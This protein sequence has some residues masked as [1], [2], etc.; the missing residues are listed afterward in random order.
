MEQTFLIPEALSDTIGRG[1]NFISFYGDSLATAVTNIGSSDRT[2]IVNKEIDCDT[3]TTIPA[4]ISLIVLKEGLITIASG[5][6]LTINGDFAAGLYQIFDGDGA[7]AGLTKSYPEWWGL[8]T[9]PGTT[10]MTAEIQAAIDA[11]KGQHGIVHFQPEAYLATDVVD[12]ENIIGFSLSG[13]MGQLGTSGTRII[14]AHTGKAIVSLVGSMLVKWKD[15]EL[16][17]DTTTTPKIGLL[18]GRSSAASAGLHD[19]Q[20]LKI[21]G[22]FTIAGYYNVASEGNIHYGSFIYVSSPIC[23][24]HFAQDDWDSIGGLTGSSMEDET[25]IGGTIANYNTTATSTALR[26]YIGSATGHFRMDNTMIGKIGGDSFILIYSGT[27]TGNTT[28]PIVLNVFGESDGVTNPDCGI[29]FTTY[30]DG[31]YYISGLTINARFQ[32]VDNYILFDNNGTA[33]VPTTGYTQLIG[34]KIN[35]PY[36]TTGAKPIA[37]NRVD[38]SDLHFEGANT[39]AITITTAYE[40]RI[41]SYSIPTITYS[42]N[43][44]ISGAGHVTTMT[45][46]FSLPLV[47]VTNVSFAADGATE[48]FEVPFGRRFVPI[49]VVI[50]AGA[51]AGATTTIAFSGPDVANDWLSAQTLSNLDAQYDAVIIQPVPNATPVQIKSYAAGKKFYATVANHSGGATNTVYLYGLIY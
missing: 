34:A 11:V 1:V 42:Y 22:S 43:N 25:W 10:D 40:S 39:E 8:N 35:I 33:S 21:Y 29:H 19:F 46:G 20:G 6:T 17:G 9:T 7:T 4:N 2:L 48:L 37:L 13:R 32:H 44:Y 26:L 14:G 18:V 30:A 24:A 5:I 27:D 50:V 51:D 15:I 47:S 31:A 38:E 16:E 3:D 49:M 23:A 28:M 36:Y 12:A 41:Y 45:N